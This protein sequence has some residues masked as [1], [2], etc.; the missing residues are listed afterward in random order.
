MS[1]VC[2]DP[3]GWLWGKEGGDGGG[4]RKLSNFIKSFKCARVKGKCLKRLVVQQ[5]AHV[6]TVEFTNARS[7]LYGIYSRNGQT[8]T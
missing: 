6:H 3:D 8:N 5:I 7:S 4:K 1:E 2:R